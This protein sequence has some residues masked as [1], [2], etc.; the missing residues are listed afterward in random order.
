MGDDLQQRTE[1][2]RSLECL[3]ADSI[4]YHQYIC[5]RVRGSRNGM[6][7]MEPANEEWVAP[8]ESGEPRAEAVDCLIGGGPL[9]YGYDPT[10][11][12]CYQPW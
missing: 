9:C 3:L 6:L 12:S 4:D 11:D 8:G 10:T 2:E 1:D 7:Q 5:Y